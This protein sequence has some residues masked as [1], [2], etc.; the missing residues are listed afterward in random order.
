[1]VAQR[2]AAPGG[3][4]FGVMRVLRGSLAPSQPC[5]PVMGAYSTNHRQ[6]IN[7]DG[8]MTALLRLPAVIECVG[9]QRT[10]GRPL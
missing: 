6:K 5:A 7:D 2:A 10:T 9:L 1:M 4:I 3:L 8:R